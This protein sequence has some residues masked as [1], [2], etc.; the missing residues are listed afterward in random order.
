LWREKTNPN[1]I[2]GRNVGVTLFWKSRVLEVTGL[3]VGPRIGVKY[4]W[5]TSVPPYK[6]ILAGY[7]QTQAA[8]FHY[9]PKS[10][11]AVVHLFNAFITYAYDNSSLNK[12]ENK[13]CP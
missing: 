8:W 6:C 10:P 2:A 3:N 7:A 13:K 5:F 9:L 12:E 11:L 1:A 4:F